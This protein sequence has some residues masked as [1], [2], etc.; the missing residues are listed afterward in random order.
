MSS[1]ETELE[2]SITYLRNTRSKF[3]DYGVD[4]SNTAG[5]K[6]FPSAVDGLH[7]KFIKLVD[8]SITEL[9]EKD[10]NGLLTIG[11]YVFIECH[12][13][14]SVVIPNSVTSIGYMAFWTCLSLTSVEIKDG[15]KGIG[16]G[17]FEFCEALESVKFGKG[18]ETIGSLAFDGCSS[19]LLYDF[20]DATSVPVLEWE[21]VF[22]GI[23]EDCKIKVPSALYN[24]WKNATNWTFYADYIVA[25]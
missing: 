11:D 6:D 15:V 12:S 13:L 14:T 20:S 25:V 3:A 10:L 8:R 23:P 19:C 21:D 7:S 22:A 5:L 9:T 4:I 17:A 24:E 1:I 18:L 16:E 2:N